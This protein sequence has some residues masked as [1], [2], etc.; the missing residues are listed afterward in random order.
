MPH[1]TPQP[2]KQGK[3]DINEKNKGECSEILLLSKTKMC[4]TFKVPIT[5]GSVRSWIF[6]WG[7]WKRNDP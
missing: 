3:N 4:G 2:H 7:I 1:P 6:G 5:D